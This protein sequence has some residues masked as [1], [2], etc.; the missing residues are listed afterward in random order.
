M[1]DIRAG[2]SSLGPLGVALAGSS[3]LLSLNLSASKLG[4]DGVTKLCQGLQ[5]ACHLTEL[6]LDRVSCGD[7][8]AG[9]IAGVLPQ[10]CLM[11]LTLAGNTICS[12]G[13]LA[14]AKACTKSKV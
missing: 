13:A 8:G 2:P 3:S 1:R 5:S 6:R 4:P 14:L 12:T 7:K 9:A 10:A 11:C